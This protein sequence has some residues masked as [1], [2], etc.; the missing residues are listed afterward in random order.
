[1]CFYL[2]FSSN[3]RELYILL[4]PVIPLTDLKFKLLVVIYVEDIRYLETVHRLNTPSE[5]NFDAI[6]VISTNTHDKHLL[7]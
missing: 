3:T 2:K 4:N 5:V 6:I 1:M 7:L